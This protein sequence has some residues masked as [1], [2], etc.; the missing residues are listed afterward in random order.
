MVRLVDENGKGVRMEEDLY[1]NNYYNYLSTGDF[2]RG[3]KNRYRVISKEV[4]ITGGGGVTMRIYVV[5]DNN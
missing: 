4:D 2:I 1:S 5:I 3:H